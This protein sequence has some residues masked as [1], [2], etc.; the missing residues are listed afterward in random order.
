MISEGGPSPSGLPLVL[1]D[2]TTTRALP[3]P[4]LVTS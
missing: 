4:T 1:I 3:E 2:E